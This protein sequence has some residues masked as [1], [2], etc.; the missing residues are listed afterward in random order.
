M[1]SEHILKEIKNLLEA[2]ETVSKEGNLRSKVQ[3]LIPVFLKVRDLGTSLIPSKTDLKLSARE[4][5][6]IYFKHYPNQIINEHELALVAGI[7]EWARRVREL[8][9]QFGWKIVSGVTA[10]EFLTDN[11]LTDG[12]TNYSNLGPND[13]ILLDLKQDKEAA[14]RWGLAN[15][16]RKNSTSVQD[17]II[18]YLRKNVG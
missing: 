7:S 12:D 3:A 16:I 1:Q 5:L 11:G 6:L 9:V 15:E 4:R 2:F 17:K 8:R 13:Y 10:R 14:Y 18:E